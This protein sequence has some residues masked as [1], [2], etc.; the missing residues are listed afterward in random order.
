MIIFTKQFIFV[1]MV[2]YVFLEV[3]AEF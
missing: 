3:G 1:T 2:R